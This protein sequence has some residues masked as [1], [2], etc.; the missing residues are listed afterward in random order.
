MVFELL[1]AD[2]DGIWTAV[3]RVGGESRT[4]IPGEHVHHGRADVPPGRHERER[5]VR[6]RVEE[7]RSGRLL[8]RRL[9]PEV[10]CRGICVGTEFVAPSNTLRSQITP[11]VQLD[12]A[13]NFVVCWL[14]Y[15]GLFAGDIFGQRFDA[16]AS[17]LVRVSSYERPPQPE[18]PGNCGSARRRLLVAWEDE[19]YYRDDI[20]AQ[21]FNVSAEK[22]GG[23]FIVDN[24]REGFQFSPA[25]SAS[26]D[27]LGHFAVVWQ[28]QA[29]KD[30]GK[31]ELTDGF[32]IAERSRPERSSRSR[33]TKPGSD[34]RVAETT[35]ARSPSGRTAFKKS[36]GGGR[37]GRRSRCTWTRRPEPRRRPIGTAFWRKARPCGSSRPGPITTAPRRRSWAPRQLSPLASPAT[38]ASRRRTAPPTTER[39]LPERTR[40]APPKPRA[41]VSCSKSAVPARG[42]TGTRVSWRRSRPAAAG[43]G[44]STSA[45]ASPTCRARSPSTGRSR[46]SFITASRR[47]APRRS[48]ARESP[49]PA[50]RWQSSSARRLRALRTS[51]RR[52]DSSAAMRTS[53]PRAATR[54]SAM[55]RQPISPADRFTTSPRGNVTR[56]VPPPRSAGTDGHARR[57]GLVHRQGARRAPAGRAVP[58]PTGPTRHRPFLFVRPPAAPTC[59][60]RTCPSRTPSASTSTIS[61]PG[62][63]WRVVRRRSTAPAR[64]QSRRDGEIHRQRVRAAALR[65]VGF[66]AFGRTPSNRCRCPPGAACFRDPPNDCGRLLRG[67]P[68]PQG[69]RGRG[70]DGR[71]GIYRM[72]RLRRRGPEEL[73]GVRRKQGNAM[74][75]RA[76]R[77]VG[78]KP[79]RPPR[80]AL[81]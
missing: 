26:V 27:R 33:R 20:V 17:R 5:G 55:W 36:S 44:R 49:C 7:L 47:V 31:N 66:T 64:G 73:E 77:P 16:A 6:R 21:R 43:P 37:F 75:G 32:S 30:V 3:G 48:T 67:G 72:R 2:G 24:E 71:I 41:R 61:G 18:V 78:T 8:Q 51:S 42:R 50:T 28:S 38:R 19:S 9:R 58:K 76:D 56:A 15:L 1:D 68:P 62:E 57:D 60:S 46:R 80:P 59:T 10:R 52:P 11:V 74:A 45:T 81:L 65:A 29:V 14:S 40:T 25:I 4:A 79:P 69:I 53:A 70:A 13:G 22:V 63:S 12:R 34:P 23:A 35:P 39:S 54:S